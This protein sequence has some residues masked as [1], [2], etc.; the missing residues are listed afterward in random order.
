MRTT[1]KVLKR[2]APM[3]FLSLL[4]LFSSCGP[5]GGQ[6]ET[7]LRAEFLKN[8]KVR[9]FKFFWD[10]ID[11]NTYQTDDRY[12]TRHFTSIAAT[13]FGLAAYLVGVENGYVPRDQAAGR[14]YQT[15]DWL[16]VSGQGPDVEGQSGYRGFYYHFLNY[17]SGTRF[18]TVELST[19]D[20][21]L[22]M[23]GIL[24]CQSYFDR[25]DPVEAGIRSLADSLFLRVEWDWA[26]NSR[27]LMSM[28]WHPESGFIDSEWSGYNEAMILLIMALGSPTH[29]IPDSSW[30]AW[31]RKYHWEEFH[32]YEHVNFSPLFGHQY[33]HMFIDFRGLWDDYMAVAGIDYFENSR[34]ATL[35]NQAYCKANPGNFRD[36]SGTIWGLTACDGPANEVHEVNGREIRFRTYSARGASNLY[37]FDDGTIAPAAAGGSIPFAPDECLEALWQMKKRY[38]DRLYQ[39]YG[40]KDAFNPTYPAGPDQEPGWFDVDY[41]GIDQGPI[42]IQLENHETGLIWE[43]VKRNRYIVTGLQKAGFRGG[44][45]DEKGEKIE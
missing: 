41:L 34:R 26:M 4:I 5:R 15:L 29:P 14:V 25:N 30:S 39:E 3:C 35:S 1:E 27:G 11:P 23:A 8:L 13:G 31:C 32:G 12:P 17:E 36:Y 20:T 19:I 45:L 24:A 40:F 10:R 2:G 28:G 33:S 6:E 44:W 9:T 21:G 43:T 18:K 7:V 22:L 42:L 38:G 37:V 16:W